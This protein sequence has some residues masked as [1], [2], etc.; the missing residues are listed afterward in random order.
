MVRL[1][2]SIP[3]LSKICAEQRNRKLKGFA[4][5]LS[6]SSVFISQGSLTDYLKANVLSWNELC[7]IAQTAAR[8]L[9]YLHED[10]PG[11]KEGHKPSIAH[12]YATSECIIIILTHVNCTL[13]DP[14]LCFRDIKSKNVLLKSNLTACVADFGLALKFEAGKS[15]G[16]TH[17]QVQF[18]FTSCPRV[19]PFYSRVLYTLTYQHAGGSHSLVVTRRHSGF[20]DHFL[21]WKLEL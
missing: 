19:M 9:S 21:V 7:H 15:A 11:H 6:S 17:G 4:L 14:F 3:A 8:G 10:I 5:N 13:H 2:Q 20:C 18:S 12:R 16:D 1:V